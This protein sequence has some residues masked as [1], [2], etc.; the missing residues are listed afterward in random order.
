MTL[1][2]S[3]NRPVADAQYAFRRL[4]KAMSEPGVIVTLP[5]EQG[6]SGL[7]PAATAVLLTLADG[8]TP[9]WIDPALHNDTVA[10]NLRFHT[11][12]PQTADPVSALFALVDA[13][14]DPALHRFSPGQADAPE[15]STTVIL[16][17]PGL[18]GG[19]NMRLWGPGISEMRAIAPQLPQAATDF[20]RHHADTFP[21][22]CDLILT[23]GNQLLAL[24]RTTHVE[25][26]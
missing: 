17:V 1:L 13:R 4:L 26:C 5:L 21:E 22:G 6:W 11:G 15:T 7:S 9:V 20:L 8:D 12:A 25:V 2:A 19:L 24:P 3:F 16:E 14:Q 18:N 23:C 10:E